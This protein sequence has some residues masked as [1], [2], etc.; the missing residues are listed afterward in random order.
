M[1]SN[2]LYFDKGNMVIGISYLV[3]NHDP[4]CM[5]LNA[6]N[7]RLQASFVTDLVPHLCIAEYE[8]YIYAGMKPTKYF[9]SLELIVESNNYVQLR[10]IIKT[11]WSRIYPGLKLIC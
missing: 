1:L 3:P 2:D 9:Y 4:Q 8:Y 5:D 7:I 6:L 11:A 10:T